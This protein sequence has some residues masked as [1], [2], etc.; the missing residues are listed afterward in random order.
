MPLKSSR[1]LKKVRAFRE[2]GATFVSLWIE[3]GDE[4]RL[5]Y[6]FQLDHQIVSLEVATEQRTVPSIYALFGSADSAEREI[7]RD[8]RIKFVGNPNLMMHEE[9]H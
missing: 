7:C 2:A 6:Y 8:Y 1:W 9:N 4:A 3:D 5:V